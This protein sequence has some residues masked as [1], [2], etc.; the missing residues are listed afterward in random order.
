MGQ[1]RRSS[2]SQTGHST[3]GASPSRGARRCCSRPTPRRYRAA[4][5]RRAAPCP[6]SVQSTRP[7]SPRRERLWLRRFHAAPAGIWGLRGH[8]RCHPPRPPRTSAARGRWPPPGPGGRCPV[9][10]PGRPRPRPARDRLTATPHRRGDTNIVRPGGL[11]RRR[12]T[13]RQ[14][15]RGAVAPSTCAPQPS[16][17]HPGSAHKT[18]A[19]RDRQ[20]GPERLMPVSDW[21]C[22]G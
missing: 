1:R 15:A 18:T 21:L 5:G 10:L 22:V 3:H 4:A 19:R 17:Q 14:A 11:R 6:Y 13:T 20:A 16:E 2:G 7:P 12:W 8:V 9:P